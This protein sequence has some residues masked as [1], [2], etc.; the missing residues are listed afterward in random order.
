MKARTVP[1]AR[2]VWP[3]IDCM[4]W[5]TQ[6]RCDDWKTVI[7]ERAGVRWVDGP[8]SAFG[9]LAASSLAP[10]PTVFGPVHTARDGGRP[11][12]ARMSRSPTAPSPCCVCFT[13]ARNEEEQ[14]QKNTFTKWI[15]LH[16]EE[17][18]SSGRV[19][20]LFEDIKDGVLLCH[21]IEVLTGEA[22]VCAGSRRFF[23]AFVFEPT[24]C[25][26][27]FLD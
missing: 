4:L 8:G 26:R 13:S 17:H 22:L 11:A 5:Y 23:A 20:D 21:L 2:C 3:P 12:V 25:Y 1:A 6:L 9:V 16:L 24:F 10:T 18:S 15:N 27:F 7:T 19:N 14:A